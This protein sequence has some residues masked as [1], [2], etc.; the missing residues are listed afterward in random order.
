MITEET[1]LRCIKSE[2]C[3]LSGQYITEGD[4][5]DIHKVGDGYIVVLDNTGEEWTF[6]DSEILNY[7][8]PHL[9]TDQK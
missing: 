4:I 8:V 7:F 6:P 5:Y 2:S 1:Q 3:M 9:L